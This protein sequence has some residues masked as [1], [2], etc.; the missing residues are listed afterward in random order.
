MGGHLGARGGGLSLQRGLLL[1]GCDHRVRR[2][3]LSGIAGHLQGDN[4]Q[5]V[6]GTDANAWL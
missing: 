2:Q 6:T 3:P 1:L 4:S 5:G